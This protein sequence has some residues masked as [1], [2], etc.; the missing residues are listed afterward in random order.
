MSGTEV[1]IWLHEKILNAKAY[2]QAAYVASQ[3]EQAPA[4]T[5]QSLELGAHRA[6]HI[7]CWQACVVWEACLLQRIGQQAAEPRLRQRVGP[8]HLQVFINHALVF[9]RRT[10]DPVAWGI[11]GVA[12]RGEGEVLPPVYR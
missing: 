8:G 7:H 11:R 2:S 5:Q 12:K 9:I 4:H 1:T 3:Y 6:R 10:I